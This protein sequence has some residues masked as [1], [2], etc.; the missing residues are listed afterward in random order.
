MRPLLSIIIPCYNSGR[1]IGNTLEMLL[2][3]DLSECEVIAVN[4]GSTDDTLD[5][6]RRYASRDD[7][8]TV[9]DQPNRGVSAARNT[10]TT[11]ATGHYVQYLDSDD[12]LPDGTLDFF[13]KT[14]AEHR[15][16]PILT[17]A[18]A[19][20][21]Q[22]RP[23]RNVVSA[24]LNKTTSGTELLHAFFTKRFYT[25]ICSCLF[26]LDFLRR[27]ELHYA[28]GVPIGEDL[29]FMILAMQ[30]ADK[31]YCSD[32]V[33][34][35][36]QIREDSTMRGYHD[37]GMRNFSNIYAIS[38]LCTEHPELARAENLFI[39]I[40]YISMLLRYIRYGRHDADV[41]RTFIELKPLLTKPVEWRISKHHC[42]LFAMRIIPVSLLLTMKKHLKP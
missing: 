34:F 10:A 6:L 2:R 28:E 11:A 18:Y 41:D 19:V 31:A 9:I 12:T 40:L 15:D 4:D 29:A 8:I 1:F 35:V 7:R 30:K 24:D 23:C 20:S 5:I 36:Y 33:S 25:Q 17:F 37:F 38:G 26:E 21:R 22:G 42:I 27:N 39:A 14:I 3:Q 13:R 16:C 32:R